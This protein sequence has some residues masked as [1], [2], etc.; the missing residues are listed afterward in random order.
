MAGIQKN[1]GSKERY[2]SLRANADK[3]TTTG[4]KARPDRR[5]AKK[6]PDTVEAAAEIHRVGSAIYSNT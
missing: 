6:V 1:S 2:S 4:T 5:L 3:K